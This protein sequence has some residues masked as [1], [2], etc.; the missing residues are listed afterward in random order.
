MT[1]CTGLTASWCPRCGDCTC[2]RMPDGD[3]CF[4][5]HDCPLH[6]TS[7][8]HAETVELDGMR[9]AVTNLANEH[10]VELSE[11]D[12]EEVAR[13]AQYLCDRHRSKKEAKG[14]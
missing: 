7:S 4:D 1:L 9:E 2:E 12:H 13:F 8:Q 10:G 6:G 5:G 14:G 3:C 11:N